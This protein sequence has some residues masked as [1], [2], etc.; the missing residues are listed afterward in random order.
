MAHTFYFGPVFVCDAGTSINEHFHCRQMPA[1]TDVYTTISQVHANLVNGILQIGDALRTEITYTPNSPP[2]AEFNEVAANAMTAANGQAARS[3]YQIRLAAKAQNIT[4]TTSERSAINQVHTH[5]GTLLTPAQQEI[6][7]GMHASFQTT[8]PHEA[9]NNLIAH[10]STVN[11]G[12]YSRI[13]AKM[14][15]GFD[16]KQDYDSQITE[17]RRQI[18]YFSAIRRAQM[19]DAEIVEAIINKATTGPM[20]IPLAKS[21]QDFQDQ[22]PQYGIVDVAR[23]RTAATAIAFFRIRYQAISPDQTAEAM[24]NH[25]VAQALLATVTYSGSSAKAT[26]FAKHLPNETAVAPSPKKEPKKTISSTRHLG[27]Q[28]SIPLSHPNQHQKQK[29]P[30]YRAPTATY[31]SN[32]PSAYPAYKSSPA[33]LKYC[34]KHGFGRHDTKSCTTIQRMTDPQEQSYY[35]SQV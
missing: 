25:L 20:A 7:K 31:Q 12:E 14:S 1:I 5:V 10:H 26:E 18:I 35:Y 6:A 34:T 23:Q 19:T 9:I 33:E 8:P 27:N 4:I 15:S 17:F 32:P 11:Q 24:V 28:H 3:N 22:Y 13:T 29:L 30:P 16:P 21:V 2:V